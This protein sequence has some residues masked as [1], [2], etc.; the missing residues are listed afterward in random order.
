MCIYIYLCIY[1]YLQKS[2]QLSIKSAHGPEF[3]GVQMFK[4]LV[5][6]GPV[7]CFETLSHDILRS[8]F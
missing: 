2:S 5:P 8:N 7:G 1:L 4:D 6:A 3:R